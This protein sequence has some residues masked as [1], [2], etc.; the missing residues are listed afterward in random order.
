MADTLANALS[1]L[2]TSEDRG[3]P[4]ARIRPASNLIK[5]VLLLLQQEG[6]VK[7]FELI[8]DGAASSF[9]VTLNGSINSCGVIRPRFAVKATDWEDYEERFLPARGVGMLIVSTPQGVLTH[10][11][12]KARHTGGRLLAFVY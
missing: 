7:E 4:I 1:S 9:A 12:A 5:H 8:E 6:Y 11:Q 10:S 2:K 3:R